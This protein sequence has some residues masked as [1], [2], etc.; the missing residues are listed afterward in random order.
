VPGPRSSARAAT[1]GWL[2]A[3]PAYRLATLRVTLATTTLAFHVPKLNALID[4]YA[5]S[6]FHVPPAF[7]WLPPPTPAAA[8]ALVA[9]GYL[10]ACGLGLGVA[11]RLCAWLLAGAGFYVLALDPEH[12]THNAHFHLTLLALIGCSGDRVTLLRLVRPDDATATCPAWPEHLVRWQL[13]IVFFYAALD[14]VVSPH[15]G[16]SGVLLSELEPTP[17][18]PGLAALQR[19]N[20]T[21]VRA[22]PAALSVMTTAL[23]F[24][25]AAAVVWRPLRRAALAVGVAFAVWLEFLVRPGTFAWDTMA[26]L[27]VLA[28]AADRG[29]SVVHDPACA[30][31]G[32]SRMLLA[33]LDWLR[34]LRWVP[35]DGAV[36]AA[37][38]GLHLIS[39]R[40]RSYRALAAA[41]VLPLVLAGPVLV[42]MTLARFGGTFLASLGYGPWFDL[43]FVV[44]AAWLLLWV[45]GLARVVR[46]PAHGA[47][48]R[49]AVRTAPR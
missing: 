16:W 34:R 4:G 20:V 17:H 42:A 36:G 25:L 13:A 46:Y 1:A 7:S 35:A 44:L 2:A 27:L 11:P 48:A 21:V 23:E 29:W 47:A 41:R 33:R 38:D 14:K 22:F 28:P 8:T 40:G 49:R 6:A 37:H 30:S 19:I 10:A 45:P 39:P 26:A 5:A 15:W 24:S 32:R 3:A 18:A 43:P 12:F 9:L 31:C